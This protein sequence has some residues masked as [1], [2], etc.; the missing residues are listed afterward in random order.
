MVAASSQAGMAPLALPNLMRWHVTTQDRLL[1][2]LSG[3]WGLLKPRVMIDLGSHASH[4]PFVNVSDALLFLDVYGKVEGSAVLAV[5]AFEDFSLDLQHRFD[6]VAPYA[7]MYGVSKKSLTFSID[8]ATDDKVV[9]F[10]GAARNHA[11]CCADLWCHYEWLERTRKADHLC[12]LTR[13]RLGMLPPEDWLPPSSYSLQTMRRLANPNHTLPWFPVRAITLET[14]WRRQLHGR[15]IDVLKVD[16]DTS[17]KNVGGLEK[18]LA[19]RMIGVMVIEVDGSWGGVSKVWNVSTLDQLAWTGRSLGYNTY[20]KVPCR[21]RRECCGSL[22]SGSWRWNFTSRKYQ[23]AASTYGEYATW[24]FPLATVG[25]PFTP[26][27]FTAHRQNGVQ[28][29]MLIDSA[30]TE[31][32]AALPSRMA[33]DCVPGGGEAPPGGAAARPS[34]SDR[35]GRRP[36]GNATPRRRHDYDVR[37]EPRGRALGRRAQVRAAPPR[38]RAAMNDL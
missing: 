21:A 37:A 19:Q 26:S 10:A 6:A 36:G 29:A 35:G 3:L 18:L 17:W 12:R 20:L 22:E 15:R 31:V 23:V 24:L 5:D 14:L 8:R 32:V 13:M 11:T 9:N 34:P 27:R 4:G 30:E 28:D 2:H 25:Q 33:S 7:S 1:H 16:I 38:N